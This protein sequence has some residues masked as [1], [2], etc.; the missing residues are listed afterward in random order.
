M[1][2]LKP[3]SL[4]W[5]TFHKV[6]TNSRGHMNIRL[7]CSSDLSVF[8]SELGHI[9]V[10]VCVRVGV[11][12]QTHLSILIKAATLQWPALHIAVQLA[13]ELLGILLPLT[14]AQQH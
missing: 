12:K 3:S 14:S 1:A 7:H 8:V 13:H 5:E 6:D 10:T 9:H 11:R 2:F 4:G